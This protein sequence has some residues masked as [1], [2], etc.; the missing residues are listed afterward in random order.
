M[1]YIHFVG[2]GGISMSALAEIMRTRGKKVSGS[3]I[4]I[5]G[6]AT[7]NIPPDADTVVINGAISD[8]NPELVAARERGL[9]IVRREELLALVAREYRNVIAVAGAHG[10]STTTAMIASIFIAAGLNPTVH[11]GARALSEDTTP[12]TLSDDALPPQALGGPGNLVIG[13]DEFFIT[14][15]CEFRRSF[16]ALHPMVSVIT[17]IDTDHMDCYR[18]LDDVIATY[19]QFAD[20]SNVVVTNEPI[21][22]PKVLEYTKVDFPLGIP[23][24]HNRENAGA[25]AAVARHF[26]IGEDIIRHALASFDGISRRFELLG[27]IDGADIITDYAHHPREIAATLKMIDGLYPRTLIVYQPHTYSRTKHLF[28]DFTDVFH[29]VDVVFYKTYSARENPIA[30]GRAEDIAMA[31]GKDCLLSERHL[32]NYICCA[33]CEYDAI[34]FMGAGDI[35][36]IARRIVNQPM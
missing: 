1:D 32:R 35:D 30:G 19:Q 9:R 33:A 2:I 13:G 12:Q 21:K 7:E 20:Q 24:E 27:G 22:H 25:A 18:D 8:D 16:L 28:T 31:T 26:G 23:G 4:S 17:N 6:H 15:A 10:K 11:N 36:D 34:I 29:D 5:N 3:D 14:E